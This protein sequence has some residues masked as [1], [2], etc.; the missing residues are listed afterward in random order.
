MYLFKDD[1]R[2]FNDLPKALEALLRRGPDSDG[3]YTNKNISLGH[4]RLSVTD[5]S[6]AAVQP[7][8]DA[9]GRYTIVLNG[10][11]FNHHHIRQELESKGA[12]FRSHSDTEVLLQLFIREGIDCLEKLNGF[13]AF[14]VYD[15]ETEEMF[16]VR[17]RFGIKPVLWYADDEKFVFAS[18]MK[19]LLAYDFPREVDEV[20]VA[21]FFKFN[22]IPHPYSCFKWVKKLAPGSYLKISPKG[23]IAEHRYY[24]V[25]YREVDTSGFVGSYDEAKEKLKDILEDSVKLRLIADVPLGVFVSG[26]IDSSAVTALASRHISHA[27]A[28]SVGYRDAPFY[29]ETEY[30]NLVA[31]K[32]KLNHTVFS[33]SDE[34]LS[35]HVAEVLDYLDEPFGDASAIPTYILS[36][37]TKK[38]VTVALSGDG[39]DEL[40]AGYYRHMAEYKARY[41]DFRVSTALAL[42]RLWKTLPESRDTFFSNKVR[43]LRRFSETATRPPKER[44]LRW[45][46]VSAEE[47]AVDLFSEQFRKNLF[48]EEIKRRD[49]DFTKYIQGAR[50][51]DDVLFSDV[52]HLL[53]DN[54]L[55][56]VDMMSMANG[57]E[58]RVPFLDYRVVNFAFSLPGKFK[59]DGRINKKIVQDTFRNILPPELY[60]RPK[61][62]FGVPLMKL[63]KTSLRSY[64]EEVVLADDFIREQGIFNPAYISELKKRL[65]SERPGDLQARIW[66]LI[67]FQHWWKKYVMS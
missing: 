28:F 58:V 12:A 34:D 63:Y 31:K 5:L 46:M 51:L 66:T 48:S 67:V 42:R 65:F 26:G 49:E 20:S 25:P 61:K 55:H 10:E 30:A 59:T 29:D 17:D 32:F 33:L 11:I 16:L 24:R 38:H 1:K 3:I 50:D 18:E 64:L 19:A 52:R 40:F 43:Q 23:T 35:E 45:A 22:Y 41:P 47:E 60:N 36:K 6:S 39:G 4:R 9:S 15:A 8:S 37:E 53:P 13:F 54:M 56:K 2:H 21:Q 57:L 62:G 14:A 27:Q 44:Y 7:M